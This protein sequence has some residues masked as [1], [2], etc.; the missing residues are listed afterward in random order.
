M[1]E[2]LIGLIGVVVGALFGGIVNSVN[3]RRKQVASGRVAARLI[4]EEIAQSRERL[5]SAKR[6]WWEGDLPTTAW[7]AHVGDLALGIDLTNAELKDVFTAYTLI[8]RWN[9]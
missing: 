1:T 7:Q 5:L 9:V 8:D 4:A 3:D 6:N 2:A